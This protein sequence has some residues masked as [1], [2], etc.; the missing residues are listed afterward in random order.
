MPAIAAVAFEMLGFWIVLV[1]PF[2]PVQEYV[3]P[4]I[5][6]PVKLIVPPIHTGPLLEAVG[7]EG[8]VFTTTVVVAAL[9]VQPATV[10]VTL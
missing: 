2:G 8:M 9:L 5:V 7:G 3:A 1:K 10:A 4:A 6:L